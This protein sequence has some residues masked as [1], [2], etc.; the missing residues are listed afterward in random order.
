M[1]EPV[2]LEIKPPE[3]E[4]DIADD[5]HYNSNFQVPT[6][7]YEPSL[8]LRDYKFPHSI[9]SKDMAAKRSFMILPNWKHTRTRS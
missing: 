9:C 7:D 6:S 8:D 5:K 2:E 1:A 3:N 4:D